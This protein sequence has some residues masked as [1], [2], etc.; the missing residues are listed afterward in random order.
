MFYKS[1]KDFYK[2]ID[3]VKVHDGGKY[4]LPQGNE[5]CIV[6]PLT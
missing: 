4:C 5:A 1:I 6:F 2:K 3:G